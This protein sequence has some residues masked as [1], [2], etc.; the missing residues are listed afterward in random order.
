M[1]HLSRLALQDTYSEHRA[2]YET[3]VLEAAAWLDGAGAAPAPDAVPHDDAPKPA[4]PATPPKPPASLRA[5]LGGRKRGTGLRSAHRSMTAEIACPVAIPDVGAPVPDA[6]EAAGLLRRLAERAGAAWVTPAAR[7][8]LGAA[9][10]VRPA[11]AYVPPPRPPLASPPPP[12]PRPELPL[13]GFIWAATG[14]T[15]ILTDG[16]DLSV[17]AAALLRGGAGTAGGAP[18][19]A[20]AAAV[21]AM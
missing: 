11:Q 18:R 5:S 7:F 19:A 10:M 21:A 3:A 17:D 1:R 20:A 6:E 2:A 16:F 8:A 12:P 9:L 4:A 14:R 13:N 15:A